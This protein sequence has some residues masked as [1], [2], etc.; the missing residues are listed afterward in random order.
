MPIIGFHD[1]DPRE[2]LPEQRD[3]TNRAYDPRPLHQR[4]ELIPPGGIDYLS[5]AKLHEASRLKTVAEMLALFGMMTCRTVLNE[6]MTV[7]VCKALRQSGSGS[8]SADTQAAHCI[9]GHILIDSIPLD[10]H[11]ESPPG[12]EGLHYTREE[13]LRKR[14]FI[15]HAFCD[16]V[17]ELFERTEVSAT[18]LNQADSFVENQADVPGLKEVFELSLGLVLSPPQG[19]IR[20]AGWPDVLKAVNYAWRFYRLHAKQ[21]VEEAEGKKM[22]E[23][24]ALHASATN[25]EREAIELRILILRCFHTVLVAGTPPDVLDV[26]G[27]DLLRRS[28]MS[29]S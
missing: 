23:R 8:K 6:Q 11:L 10:E 2:D 5:A 16:K 1:V 14:G 12:E 29:A 15:P 9:P 25:K 7:Q 3:H 17:R 4:P 21:K 19:S 24:A 27:F 26:S 18:H 13:F 20:R 28:V 22:K